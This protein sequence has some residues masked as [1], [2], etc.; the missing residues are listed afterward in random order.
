MHSP[1]P[2]RLGATARSRSAVAG[3]SGDCVGTGACVAT[4]TADRAVVASFAATPV[5]P[6]ANAITFVRGT[7]T[8]NTTGPVCYRTTTTVR[9]WGCSAFYGRTVRVNGGPATRY[10]GAGPFPLPKAADGFTY[11]SVSAGFSPWASLS[12]W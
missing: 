9:G 11:F 3:W 12:V 6:C 1:Q 2:S 10:C 5:A 8:F 7:G 4:M